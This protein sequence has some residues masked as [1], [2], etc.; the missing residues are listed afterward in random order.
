MNVVQRIVV[1]VAHNTQ[2]GL[3]KAKSVFLTKISLGKYSTGKVN[4]KG[5][6]S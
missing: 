6:V 4:E 1:P 2:C 5:M 3:I